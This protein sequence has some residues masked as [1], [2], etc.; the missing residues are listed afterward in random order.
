MANTRTESSQIHPPLAVPVMLAVLVLA[1]SLLAGDLMGAGQARNW[2]HTLGF[3]GMLSLALLVIL[4]I[5]HPRIGAVR[6]DPWDR[7]FIQLRTSMK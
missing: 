5:E 6:I 1:C 3:A 7:V 2:V 4:D